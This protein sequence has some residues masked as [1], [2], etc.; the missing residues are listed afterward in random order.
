MPWTALPVPRFNLQNA[1]RHVGHRLVLVLFAS[2]TGSSSLVRLLFK[3][4]PPN[5]VGLSHGRFPV[6]DVAVAA[7]VVVHLEIH[8]L[9]LHFVKRPQHRHHAGNVI[10]SKLFLTQ[11]S[12]ALLQAFIFLGVLVAVLVRM[13]RRI[14]SSN[15]FGNARFRFS[16]GLCLAFL[17][18]MFERQGFLFL[19]QHHQKLVETVRRNHPPQTEP[20]NDRQGRQFKNFG[21]NTGLWVISI[22]DFLDGRFPLFSFR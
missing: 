11:H 2:S 7:V 14:G 3:I 1:L 16:T 15:V 6:I 8:L 17:V 20:L 12:T 22:E 5:V 19:V 9:L 21:W 18:Q 4:L 13:Y 10:A